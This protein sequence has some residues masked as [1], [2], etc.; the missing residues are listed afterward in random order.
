MNCPQLE[1]WLIDVARG[2]M[3]DAARSERLDRHLRGCPQCVARL[4]SERAISASL[5]RLAKD[6]IVPAVDASSEVAL[7]R[8]LDAAHWNDRKPNRWF[9]YAAAA[10][11]LF[12]VAT[13]TLVRE[14]EPKRKPFAAQAS[15]LEA[16]PPAR[17]VAAAPKAAVR[18]T[19]RRRAGTSSRS[20]SPGR[21]TPFVT[22]PGTGDLPA[23]ESG[24]LLRVQLPA[25][26]AASLGLAP[27]ARA[28]VVQADVLIGQDGF[29]RAVRLAP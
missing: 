11:T 18:S 23:F 4:E 8:E 1:P 21:A 26:V 15:L 12:A 7:L 27:S 29:A 13:T 17:L 10:A 6:A 22:W 28:A 20:P 19:P 14:R 25:S 24:Q 5:R 2:V 9:V 16:A 3:L